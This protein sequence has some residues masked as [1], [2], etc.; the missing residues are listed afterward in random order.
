MPPSPSDIIGE[1]PPA[2]LQSVI[3]GDV[4]L[5]S[6][7]NM[8]FAPPGPCPV[9]FGKSLS[10]ATLTAERKAKKEAKTKLAKEKKA[11]TAACKA[12]ALAKKQEKQ[13]KRISI[14]LLRAKTA[15]SKAA[16]LWGQLDEFKAAGASDKANPQKKIKG[17]S[18]TTT[19]ISSSN[20]APDLSPTR[21]PIS[22]KK[23]VNVQSP[24][25]A[26][27]QHI[28]VLS[29]DQL[30]DMSLA[31][32]GSDSLSLASV[33][34]DKESDSP[35]TAAVLCHPSAGRGSIAQGRGGRHYSS[36]GRA[37]FWANCPREGLGNDAIMGQVRTDMQVRTDTQ[38]RTYTQGKGDD[39]ALNQE[40]RDILDGICPGISDSSLLTRF[41]AC[42]FAGDVEAYIPFSWLFVS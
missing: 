26:L 31:S 16:T 1:V 28:T 2:V 33:N 23:R 41:I 15:A 27:F 34:L 5:D 32:G 11:A 35:P 37:R 24:C 36:P 19:S 12:T 17:S 10:K 25:H 6:L 7:G 3:L 29:S 9:R 20:T 4:E 18:G 30:V 40:E 38:V 8:I 39:G 13:E 42:H 22:A 21:K 14:A